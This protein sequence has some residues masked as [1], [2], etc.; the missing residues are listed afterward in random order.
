[1]CRV[2][3]AVRQSLIVLSCAVGFV[4]LIAC[5][6]LANLLLG[7]ATVRRRE[8]AVRLALGARRRRLVRLLLTESVLLALLG[9]AAS[10][11]VAW[12]GT[13]AL[14]SANPLASL[15]ALLG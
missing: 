13:R 8:I 5:V 10:V 6:N 7:R 4:L 1:M 12:W 11:A 15:Q 2:S 9:G 3:A 14:S